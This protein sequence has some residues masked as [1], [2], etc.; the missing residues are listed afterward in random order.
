MKSRRIRL[1]ISD[2]CVAFSTLRCEAARASLRSGASLASHR[3]QAL[4]LI[5]T[6]ASGWLI[7]WAIE[8]VSCPSE[9]T[10]VTRSNSPRVLSNASSARF[11]ST[12]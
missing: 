2:A 11:R 7:S 4:A 12:I 3:T 9:V 10:R 6:A 1:M 8:A 5:T